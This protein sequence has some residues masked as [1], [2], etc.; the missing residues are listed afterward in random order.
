MGEVIIVGNLNSIGDFGGMEQR[1]YVDGKCVWAGQ[2]DG[3]LQQI[4]QA[5]GFEYDYWP[6]YQSHL[7]LEGIRA[8]RAEEDARRADW[9]AR[10][11]PDLFDQSQQQQRERFDQIVR[12]P[13]ET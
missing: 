6:T 8:D 13:K 3:R 10:G 5:L 4:V 9:V 2:L 7:N 11:G 1:L 12:G